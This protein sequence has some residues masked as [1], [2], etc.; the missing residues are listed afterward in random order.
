M[1][2]NSM[3]SV[4]AVTL[5]GLAQS[6]WGQL[7]DLTQ[8]PNAAGEGIKKNLQEQIDASRGSSYLP[9]SSYYLIQRDPFRSVARGRQLFQRKFTHL[10]G[11]G[12]R[13]NDGVGN[14][15]MDASLGAGIADSCAGCHGRPRGAAGAGGVVFTR[16]DS[17][18]APHLFG[19]GLK[20]MLADEITA[21]LRWLRDRARAKAAASGKPTKVALKSKG[22]NYGVLAAFPNGR[23]DYEGV[24]GV[25]ADLRV[26]PF[27]HDGREWSIRGFTAGALNAEMGLEAFDPDLIAASMGKDVVTPSG[28]MLS[29][30]Q[31]KVGPSVASSQSDDPDQDGVMNEID[32]AVLD[33]LEFYLLN[34]F[35]PAL[36]EQTGTTKHG[37]KI[38]EQ[39]GCADC[40]VPD[41]T[42]DHDRRVADVRTAFDPN[43]GRQN[44]L[45]ATANK[46]CDPVN[47]GSGH[48]PLQV[49]WGR[50]YVVKNIFADFKRHDLGPAFHERNFDGT[51]AT[52]FMT[53]P[54]WG[55]GSTAPY[56]H[57]GRS[58]NLKEVILRHGGEAAISKARFAN[59][60]DDDQQRVL[61][62]LGAMV[63]FGPPDTASNLDP[64][65]PAH[66]EYPVKAHGS[67]DLSVLFNDPTDKE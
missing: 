26:K 51:V 12:P 32:V 47:D 10:Q 2:L 30:S 36:Y 14:I 34:Y 9:G 41:L 31:D 58:I 35:P 53:A 55:V 45:F 46:Q 42:I 21:E 20:E 17:R 59:L 13:T 25:D 50:R 37:R 18:D 1:R 28:M 61:A 27:F 56:G 66:P 19:L 23:V 44:R 6:A 3:V 39:I 64:G 57:D 38:F 43:Q 22:I 8:T 24:V 16:P 15:E 5:F 54:L 11:L 48:P 4:I 7:N 62:F 52:R 60:G 65:N 33:H 40:H 67:I 29:G 49:P 63:L